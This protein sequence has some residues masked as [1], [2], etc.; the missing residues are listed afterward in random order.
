MI[1]ADLVALIIF[2][3]AAILGM[4]FGF[5]KMLKFF[6]SGVFGVIISFIVCYFLYG[7]VVSWQFAIDLMAKIT[8]SLQ[9]AD[10][11]FCNF[12]ISIRIDLVALCVIMFI[13]VQL[14]RVII[15]A[16]IKNIAEIDKPFFIVINKLFG[17]LLTISMVLILTLVVFQVIYLVGGTTATNLTEYLSGSIFN[18]DKL[19][20]NN[21]LNDMI[22][23]LTTKE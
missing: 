15:V 21:P 19:F 13:V 14:L 11:G 8:Q 18:L 12:L 4:V 23:S 6:T 1:T 17:I 10:N 2:A 22:T 7:I 20:N 9:D 3:V 5:G 16:I